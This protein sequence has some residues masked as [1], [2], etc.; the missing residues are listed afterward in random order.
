M[1]DACCRI[2]SR[3]R[4]A[5]SAAKSV[6]SMLELAAEMFSYA[7]PRLLM[8]APRVYFSK[9]PNRPPK[10]ADLVDRLGD[11]ALGAGQVRAGQGVRAAR[12]KANSRYPLVASPSELVE[13]DWMPMLATPVAPDCGAQR[14]GGPAAGDSEGLGPVFVE[15]GGKRKAHDVQVVVAVRHVL[16][17]HGCGSAR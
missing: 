7:T 4:L 9:A 5:V 12:A 16:P 1:V 13:T 6:S 17:V 15:S 11:N 3:V 14:E 10:A 8:V 2:C